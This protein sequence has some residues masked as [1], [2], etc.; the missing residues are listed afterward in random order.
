MKFVLIGT[1]SPE[2]MGSKAPERSAMAFE[3]VKALG[4]EVKVN[5][6]TQGQFDFV[7]I[8]D[9]PDPESASA[10]SLWYMQQG[11]GRIQTMRAYDS[12]EFSRISNKINS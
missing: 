5:Y 6:F 10:F 8:V 2:W 3:K 4:L 7:T 12:D 9:A 11:F 1:H